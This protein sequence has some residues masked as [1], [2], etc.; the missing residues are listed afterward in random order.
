MVCDIA[1][2][3]RR[4]LQIAEI[5]F[6]LSIEASACPATHFDPRL[7]D[8]WP[9]PYY[10]KALRRLGELARRQSAQAAYSSGA[11]KLASLA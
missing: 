6:A 8:Y 7:G 2:T 9:D 5:I 1:L 10:Q 4:R 3:L 11:D